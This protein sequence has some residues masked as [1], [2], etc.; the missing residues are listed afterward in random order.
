MHWLK[1]YIDYKGMSV[2]AFEK[3][4]DTRSAIDKAIKKSSNLRSD[5]L[6]KIIEKYPDVNPKW[7]L[8]GKGNM[9]VEEGSST[10]FKVTDTTSLP[11]VLRYLLENNDAFMK[12]ENF[13]DYIKMNAKQLNLK[14]AIE[15]NSKKIEKL[16][17]DAINRFK[18]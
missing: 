13:R 9:L 5:I 17:Q 4:V 8:S 10:A 2:L 15:E 6:A 1:S 11:D 7:L 3:S 12:N 18:K 16:R 14:E